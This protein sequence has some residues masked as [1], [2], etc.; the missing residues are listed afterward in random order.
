[1]L[2][3]ITNHQLPITITIILTTTIIIIILNITTILIMVTLKT[4]RG[5]RSSWRAGQ[6]HVALLRGDVLP[7]GTSLLHLQTGRLV[8]HLEQVEHVTQVEQVKR[9]AKAFYKCK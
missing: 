4:R 8:E 1:M 2:R 6:R 5:V 7:G 9:E 3:I